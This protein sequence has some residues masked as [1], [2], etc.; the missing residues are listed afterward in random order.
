MEALQRVTKYDG[1]FSAGHPA[2]VAFWSVVRG[3]P[4]TQQKQLLFFTTG[5]DRAPVGGLGNLPFVV[6]RSGPDTAHLPTSHTVGGCTSW[7]Q[8]A[9]SSA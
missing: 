1:G 7:I 2:V 9:R 6:Q 4:L 5:C 3:M 8:S